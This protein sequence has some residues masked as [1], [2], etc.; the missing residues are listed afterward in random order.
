MEALTRTLLAVVAFG[1]WP[2]FGQG[3]TSGSDGSDG[4]L[5]VTASGDFDP[6]VLGLDAD[7]DG[8]YHF[9]S[10]NV[11]AGVTLRLRSGILGE[12]RPVVW[13]SQGDV[14]ISGILNLDG[15]NGHPGNNL[16]LPSE[17]GAGG[18]NGG[19]G[20]TT[21]GA[22]SG[23]GPGGGVVSAGGNGGGAGHLTAGVNGSS[24]STGGPA[25]GNGFLLP[26][27]GGSGGAGGDVAGNGGGGAGGGAILIA[28]DT[29]IVVSGAIQARGGSSSSTQ[30]GSGSGGSVR[31][32]AP[33]VSGGGALRVDGSTSGQDSS[34]GRIRV[35]AFSHGTLS[36]SPNPSVAAFTRPGPVLLPATAPRVRATAIV[37]ADTTTIPI[38]PTPSGSY[39]MPDA[40]MNTIDPITLNVAAEN[41]PVAQNVTVSVRVLSD[42]GGVMV[43]SST[44]LSGTDAASTATVGPFSLPAGF[45]RF[46]LTVTFD[47][48]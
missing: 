45:S 30:A 32:I 5:N 10:I 19:V 48:Q 15:V 7:G 39:A 3:F 20:R 34:A 26:L 17:A 13:L 43:L 9:T 21:T 28:S 25:Y 33:T 35:E 14:T 31:L 38:S 4:A 44:P 40:V 16:A 36:V 23:S 27:T 29:Q 8:V 12:G 24:P 46:S 42:D 6:A 47:P 2:A 37:L 18:Y 22:T 1:A 41:V 11:N